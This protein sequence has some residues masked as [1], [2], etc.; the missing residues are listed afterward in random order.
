VLSGFV[1]VEELVNSFFSGPM[2]GYR[3]AIL[4]FERQA[5]P[6]FV[7]YHAVESL[8]RSTVK[9]LL[10]YSEN[11]G[12]VKRHHY[13][14]LRSGLSDR[15]NVRFMLVRNKG[16]NPNYTEEAVA[17]L[18]EFS[19]ARAKLDILGDNVACVR[20]ERE[21]MTRLSELNTAA[22]D[23]VTALCL[24][25]KQAASAG[26]A[27]AVACAFR[28]LVVPAMASLRAPVDEMETLVPSELWPFP[29]YG[30]MTYRQ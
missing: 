29:T 3:K 15:E 30:E 13:D 10:I 4:N 9:A 27:Y 26:D 18:G 1:A 16:H 11:D 25:E 5:N 6:A 17:L 23:A 22:Y 28:D 20:M 24:A 7:S 8:K 21:L 19:A 14:L 12:M 2:K